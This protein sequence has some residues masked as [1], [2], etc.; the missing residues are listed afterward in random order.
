MVELPLVSG[1][2]LTYGRL[3]VAASIALL[4]LNQYYLYRS[5]VNGTDRNARKR[6]FELGWASVSSSCCLGEKPWWAVA[7][8]PLPDRIKRV[9]ENGVLNVRRSRG[10][11]IKRD[12]SS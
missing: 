2:M 9:A 4:W 3:L 10:V 5:W 7:E 1:A 12:R 11:Q 8:A 6:K